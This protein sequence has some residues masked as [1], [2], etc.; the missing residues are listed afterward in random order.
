MYCIKCGTEIKP[1]QKFCTNCGTPAPSSPNQR[2]SDQQETDQDRGASQTTTDQKED[3]KNV[4]SYDAHTIVDTLNQYVGG[5][6]EHVSLNWKVLFKDVFKSH[7]PEEAEEIFACGSPT[8]TPDPQNVTSNWP[9]PWLY[10]RVFFGFVI[11]FF[12]LKICAETFEN[13]KVL[14]GLMVIGSFAAP[15]ALV[16]MFMELNVFKNIS[17]YYV[18]KTFLIGGCASLLLTMILYSFV[19]PTDNDMTY[20][21]AFGVSIAEELGK[22]LIVLFF[23]KRI[24]K[25]HSILIGLLVGASVG[26]GFAAFESAGYAFDTML[27]G[28]RWEDFIGI[29]YLRGFLAPGGHV[30]WAAIS[31]VAIV[32]ANRS[33]QISINVLGEMRFWKLFII[34]IICH[35]LWD[36]P[37]EWGSDYYLV[38]LILCVVIWI[39]VLLLVN[40]GLKEVDED[41]PATVQ[42]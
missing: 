38:Q 10:S 8:T 6:K 4:E 37:I 40:M 26:A 5:S 28:S 29:I 17:F 1:G 32:L 39:F 31:G 34:P 7:S 16:V 19:V 21:V 20:A 13:E 11:A 3:A 36:S 23:L 15:F 35:W 18:M 24:T 42:Q 25:T 41:T 2:E 30:A 12:I 27:I 33:E 9:H 22:A 14:P